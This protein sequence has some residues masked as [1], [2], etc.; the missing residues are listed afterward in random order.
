M[1]VQH[2]I[3][4]TY[5]IHGEGGIQMVQARLADHGLCS[6]TKWDPGPP[7]WCF[8]FDTHL[9]KPE[10]EQILIDFVR[11]YAIRVEVKKQT[12]PLRY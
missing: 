4:R 8:V 3:N 11:R 9:S 5:L 12:Q 2:E 6:F 10:L 7:L 1:A